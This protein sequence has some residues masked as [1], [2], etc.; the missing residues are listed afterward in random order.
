M[1]IL[2]TGSLKLKVDVRLLRSLTSVKTAG[3]TF[4]EYSAPTGDRVRAYADVWREGCNRMARC[5]GRRSNVR[6][7]VLGA[8]L[9]LAWASALGASEFQTND[10]RHLFP[11]ATGELRA[12][13]I[14]G[15]PWRAAAPLPS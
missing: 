13:A 1:A 4:G 3:P 12:S 5:M 9:V 14:S 15:N 11:G 7:P 8:C 6:A 2:H 10:L